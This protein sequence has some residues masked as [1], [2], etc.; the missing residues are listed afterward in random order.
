M[1]R[2]PVLATAAASYR[3]LVGEIV[4]ILRLSWLPL[5]LVTLIQNAASAFIIG[6]QN[7][8]AAAFASPSV[9]AGWAIR[10]FVFAL[11]TSMVA[12]ALHRVI[13]F[14]R[15][16]TGRFAYLYLGKTELLFMLP[17]LVATAAFAILVFALN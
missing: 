6:A 12:V 13:L 14:G 11:G 4:T 16:Q 3:F 9:W 7:H 2:L 1:Q 15:R 5:L 17:P 10:A 8:A